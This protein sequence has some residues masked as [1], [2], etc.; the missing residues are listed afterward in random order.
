MSGQ[1][2]D[3]ARIRR[4]TAPRARVTASRRT[5]P[6]SAQR[7]QGAGGRTLAVLP[8]RFE[9]L[10]RWARRGAVLAAIAGA[11]ALLFAIHVPQILGTYLGEATGRAG[12]AV[13]RVEPRGL[14]RMDPM[15]VYAAAFDQTSVAMPLVDLDA[16]RQK[17]LGYGWVEDARVSRRLPDT[18][19]IDIVERTPAAVWQNQGRL[20]LI[21]RTGRPLAPVRLEAMPD[22][23]LVIGPDANRQFG[24]LAQLI[25][26]APQLK[27]LMAGA[28][29]VGGRR[30]DVRFQSGET[31]ALPEGTAQAERALVK[32]QRIDAAAGLL[33][34]GYVRF[35]MRLP[36]PIVMRVSD[37][38][39]RVVGAEPP[40]A[41]AAKSI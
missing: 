39:G 24:G 23:P 36:G 30:W 1:G 4:G 5:S 20:T 18:L 12:F 14:H 19:V 6:R 8:P 40:A 13:K 32:F 38:P 29:W 31:L 26:A 41:T 28:S 17:L 34:Q 16:I 15:V 7:P 3:K 35:D 9:R 27:P 37:E 25:A 11:V 21:D 10:R 33:G 22:L 2:T